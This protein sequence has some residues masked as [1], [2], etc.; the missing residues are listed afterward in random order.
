M[1]T[2]LKVFKMPDFKFNYSF[3]DK[4]VSNFNI[5][6]NMKITYQNFN[7]AAHACLILYSVEKY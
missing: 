4:T 7:I 1:H 2:F 3:G 6:H 5:G